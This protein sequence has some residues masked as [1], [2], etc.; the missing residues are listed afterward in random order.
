MNFSRSP[1]KPT[2][3]CVRFQSNLRTITLIA[4]LTV[5]ASAAAAAAFA[6]EPDCAPLAA[7][8][9]DL[10]GLESLEES[11]D[12]EVTESLWK[13]WSALDAYFSCYKVGQGRLTSDQKRAI[14][15]SAEHFGIPEALLACFLFVESRFNSD[16]KSPEGA[17]GFAQ[18][19]P[20]T[21]VTIK[22]L[23]SHPEKQ[24]QKD[25][26]ETQVSTQENY[27][28]CY[29]IQRRE[30]FARGWDRL[31]KKFKSSGLI[32]NTRIAF[33]VKSSISS[34]AMGAMLYS[35]FYREI[36]GQMKAQVKTPADQLKIFKLALAAYNR[37]PDVVSDEIER[38]GGKPKLDRLLADVTNIPET[39]SHVGGVGRCMER[40]NFGGPT[41]SEIGGAAACKK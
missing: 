19:T 8:P 35:F 27:A 18:I 20:D 1:E 33:N 40:E 31:A 5:S 12:G 22:T 36:E 17:Q 25:C 13:D 30:A 29:Q 15:L 32:K 14:N 41:R 24:I 23:N 34:I 28:Y 16:A 38:L 2:M 21:L 4:A 11:P 37:G 6:Y 9:L 3:V 39:E 26:M 7:A 10:S